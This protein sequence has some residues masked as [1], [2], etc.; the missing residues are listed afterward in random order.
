MLFPTLAPP[1]SAS[2]AP[3][4]YLPHMRCASIRRHTSCEVGLLHTRH[5]H[6]SIFRLPRATA[7]SAAAAIAAIAAAASPFWVFA[8]GSAAKVAASIRDN[9]ALAFA[10]RSLDLRLSPAAVLELPTRCSFPVNP[11]CDFSPDAFSPC[12]PTPPSPPELA[13]VCATLFGVLSPSP[14]PC[15]CPRPPLF[16][17]CAMTGGTNPSSL[18]SISR[19]ASLSAELNRAL[20]RTGSRAFSAYASLKSRTWSS[21]THPKEFSP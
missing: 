1:C 5:A 11:S 14:R 9:P 13:G 20:F 10:E 17:R 12:S 19:N 6:P 21:R 16:P 4:G 2:I 3:T 7:S 18:C 15:P 8:C